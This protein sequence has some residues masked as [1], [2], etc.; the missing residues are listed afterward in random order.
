MK[1]LNTYKLFEGKSPDV[2]GIVSDSLIDLVDLGLEP[3][4]VDTSYHDQNRGYYEG[5]DRFQSFIVVINSS[6]VPEEDHEDWMKSF[7]WFDI[8]DSLTELVS[9][10]SSDYKFISGEMTTYIPEV[11]S[12]VASRQR[13]PIQD[14]LRLKFKKGKWIILDGSVVVLN[15]ASPNPSVLDNIVEMNLTFERK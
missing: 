10:L 5:P 6:E 8:C 13:D 7:K 9:Q 2:E 11:F 4:V 12:H 3:L 1:Y 15:G 14:E